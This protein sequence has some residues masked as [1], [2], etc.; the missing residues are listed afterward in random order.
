MKDFNIL[1]G[2]LIE[3]YGK[4]E[5]IE[6]PAQVKRIYYNAFKGNKYL[7]SIK[8]GKDVS[9]IMDNAF[10]NCTSLE[11][12]IIEG[13][14]KSL[15]W[16]AFC[17]C[18]KLQKIILPSTIKEIGTEAFAKCNSLVEFEI[19]EGVEKLEFGAFRECESLERIKI[20]KSLKTIETG[21]FSCCLKI[22]KVEFEDKDAWKIRRAEIFKRAFDG[23][24]RAVIALESFDKESPLTKLIIKNIVVTVDYLIEL[25]RIDLLS[26]L[27]EY[28]SKMSNETFDELLDVAQKHK[29]IE[30][31]AL[32]LEYKNNLK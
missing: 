18:E 8:I 13:E 10:E 2:D 9:E 1:N 25:G 11:S 32:L 5:S 20:P 24:V 30:A 14:L 17:G 6:I 15:P 28:K 19:P 26:K 21:A 7:K 12:V 4:E 27:L 23:G 31:V 22:S 3:Y 29:S 16:F